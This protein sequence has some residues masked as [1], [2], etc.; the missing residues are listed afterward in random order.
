[1]KSISSVVYDYL[2][3]SLQNYVISMYGKKIK[4]ERFVEEY[5]EWCKFL[6]KSQY[7]T[8]NEL[9]EYQ[10]ERLKIIIAYAFNYVPYYTAIFNKLR[11]TPK[12]IKTKEDLQKL[13]VLEKDDIRKN[14]KDLISAESKD[15]RLKAGHTSGTTGSPLEIL[16]DRNIDILHN[17][18]IWRHRNWAGFKFGE[19][20][21][22]L[23]GRVVVPIKQNK[24]PFFRINKH[25]NQYLFSSFHL[26]SQNLSHYI[27]M[28]EKNNIRYMEAYPSTAY[29]LAKYLEQIDSYYN[30]KSI[31]TSSET[32][33]PIQREVIE[34]RFKCKVYDYYGMAE[35]VMFSGEC[36]KQNG[37]HMHMEY[38]LTEIVDNENM[39]VPNGNYGNLVL[40]GLHNFAMPLIRYKIGDVTAIKK[41]KCKCGRTL[42]LLESVTTKAEDIVVTKDG[43]LI[44]SS[45]L[46][47]PFKPMHNI[48]KSQIIQDD[49]NQLVIKIVKRPGYTDSDTDLLIKSMKERTGDEMNIH[50]EFVD[51]IPRNNRGKYRWVVSK[52]PLTF[53]SDQA[54]N[55]FSREDS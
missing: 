8:I 5:N 32:L 40:T 45:V 37:H 14:F 48:L 31:V 35:R 21:A 3:V 11:L 19:R 27:E 16:W 55:L 4:K 7:F 51:D 44:S 17:V 9:E 47:H 13:P 28:F 26:K 20:Y 29:I 50:V 49:Y 22:S 30:M 41:S 12:D 54:N 10:N 52:L 6:E 34:K 43:R 15:K 23:L 2:P 39:Q 18:A 53:G 36:E 38:G 46:T 25:W 33:L 42:P 24:P 1:M